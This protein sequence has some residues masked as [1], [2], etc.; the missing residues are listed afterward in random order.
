MSE[1]A[2]GDPRHEQSGWS[3]RAC[4]CMVSITG[5]IGKERIMPEK[6]RSGGCLCGAVRFAVTLDRNA[7]TI[8]HC[9]MCRRWCGGPF[10]AAHCAGVPDFEKEDGLVW[11]RSSDWGERGFCGR[12]GTSLFWRLADKPDTFVVSVEALDDTGGFALDRHIYI[13]KK[14]DYYDFADDRP[15]MTEAEFLAEWKAKSG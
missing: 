11:Y 4:R 3:G 5:Y 13:D 10:E 2:I 12:C 7:F 8:C 6:T 15:R 1:S 9:G 14:P